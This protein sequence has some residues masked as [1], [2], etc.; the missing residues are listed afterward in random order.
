MNV[1]MLYQNAALPQLFKTKLASAVL[2]F[3]SSHNTGVILCSLNGKC[4]KHFFIIFLPEC[5]SFSELEVT[6]RTT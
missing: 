4:G 3:I 2:V 1:K 5:K 6:N